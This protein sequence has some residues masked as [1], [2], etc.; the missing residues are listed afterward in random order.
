MVV[1]NGFWRARLGSD[2]AVLGRVLNIASQ[3]RTIVGVMPPDFVFPYKTMLGPSGFSRSTDVEA[4]LPLQF[5]NSN[6]R[7]TGHVALTRDAR[8]LSVVGR[9]KPGVTAAQA[10]AEIAGI[11]RQLAATYPAS[12]R[13][14]G[15]DG[16]PAA[17]TGGRGNAAGPAPPARR[18]RIRPADGVR[19][20]REPAARAQQRAPARDGD[21]IRARRR[22]PPAD[23]AD[24]G[25]DDAA[26]RSREGSWR[27]SRST[28]RSAR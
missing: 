28:G 15:G 1:S 10:D 11:A 14:V 19:Q 17:R 23:H 22:P 21:S 4:W 12:N 9:L 27:S 7:Q 26:V 13:V 20:P 18:R 24:D 3:P 6:S 5:V 25:G 16:R 8:F 2:P